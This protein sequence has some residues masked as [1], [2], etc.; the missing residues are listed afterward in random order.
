MDK[1][2]ITKTGTTTV[3]IVC[4]N[5]IVLAADK[6]ATMGNFI[7]GKKM[8][9]VHQIDDKIGVTIAGLVSDAQLL[10]KLIKAEL[11]LKKVRTDT[12]TTL[13]EAANLLAGMCYANIRRMSMVPGIVGFVVGGKD[14]T[15]YHLYNI[16]VSG[17]ITEEDEYTSDG[18]GCVFAYG[19][20]ETLYKKDLSVDE[21]IKLAVKAVN[22]ALQRD[23]ASGCGIDIITITESGYK[24]VFTK[25][26]LN[27]LEL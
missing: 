3:G 22:A 25:E 15:G 27:K 23:S 5:G 12:E 16:D 17:G 18:S 1:E 21:G 4:K 8:E 24:K 14:S 13:K 6:R 20:F 7:A 26:M 9:K 10:V 19:V 2:N 11:R